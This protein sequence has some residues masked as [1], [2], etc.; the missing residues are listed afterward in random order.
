MTGG[1]CYNE[2][3]LRMF[4]CKTYAE[5][6]RRAGEQAA[7]FGKD[8]S[9]KLFAFCEDKLTMSLEREVAH[10]CGGGTFNV[11]V[12]PISRFIRRFSREKGVVLNKESSAMA[13]K[14]ILLNLADE[15]VCFKRSAYNPGTAV[16]LY[17]L[18]SQLK[19]AKVSPDDLYRGAAALSGAL[20]GKIKD[21]ITVY[22]AYET[23][24]SEEGFFDSNSYLALMP[25]ILKKGDFKGCSAMMVGFGSLTRQGIDIVRSLAENMEN[26]SV[27][28]LAGDNADLYTNELKHLL[29]R[30]I[31]GFSLV[32][33]V[34]RYGA[35]R[36]AVFRGLFLP[37]C[38]DLPKI[39][40]ERIE[41]Y[42]A[43]DYDDE[44]K[45]IASIIR[46]NVVGGM[47][48]RDI[49]VAVGNAEEYYNSLERIF[50]DYEIPFFI[51]K[52]RPLG[53]H[54]MAALVV[55]YLDLLKG[56]FAVA[57]AVSLEKNP[58][59][60]GDKRISDAF[61]NFV[62]RNAV[63]RKTFKSGLNLTLNGAERYGSEEEIEIFERERERILSLAA[64]PV[65]VGEYVAEVK[66]L[67]SLCAAENKAVDFAKKLREY[68]S[69]IFAA[70]TE[71]AYE[72]I[73]T[74]LDAAEKVLGGAKVTAAEFKNV[75]VSGFEA[76]KV[77]VLPQLSDAVYVGDYKECK[78]L[79]HKI[80]FAA[81]LSGEVPFA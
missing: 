22:N 76:C 8:P 79:E 9:K 14:N 12:L 37:T 49:A 20:E 11:Q 71:Q 17:E 35:E 66:K 60:Q 47:R 34:E 21:I 72:K 36:E 15:L 5:I 27:F 64:H 18:I 62:L 80:L 10:A 55:K 1:K 78:Y 25:D 81:G 58:Y 30:E 3:M 16:T 26:L 52:K 38:G 7:E 31:E 75:I 56:N 44:V 69:P 23:Y 51:D 77:A 6:L 4:V 54:P 29:M 33:S 74:V 28:I 61:E 42:E 40:T 48:Y 73:L 13:V 32:E 43:A 68:D 2:N 45:R 67:L 41:I 46:S 59:F 24:L 63:T 70:F 53:S 19:S 65:T 57:D 50:G 39:E